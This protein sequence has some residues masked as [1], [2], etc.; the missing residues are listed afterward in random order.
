M[1]TAACPA[2]AKWPRRSGRTST[3]ALMASANTPNRRPVS[4]RCCPKRASAC[5]MHQGGHARKSRTPSESTNHAA[6]TRKASVRFR[7]NACARCA[8]ASKRAHGLDAARRLCGLGPS[9]RQLRFASRPQNGRS[10]AA[11]HPSQRRGA[12]RGSPS[13][14]PASANRAPR[15]S[16]EGGNPSSSGRIEAVGAQWELPSRNP[17]GAP[18]APR[19][20]DGRDTP[21]SVTGRTARQGSRGPA[22]QLLPFC[23][24]RPV[25]LGRSARNL[26]KPVASQGV[27]NPRKPT[28]TTK[29]QWGPVGLPRGAKARSRQRGPVA[30]LGVTPR[31]NLRATLLKGCSLHDPIHAS[32][33]AASSTTPSLYW[34]LYRSKSSMSSFWGTLA[35]HGAAAASAALATVRPPGPLSWGCTG[36]RW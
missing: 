31:K 26:G 3:V 7:R 21:T 22:S 12:K 24:A 14:N 23:R 30:P 4:Y 6:K 1:P 18:A 35:A 36:G 13:R 28:S 29:A 5:D 15:L 19:L 25:D 20:A 32:R 10:R 17:S 8:P 27:T 34:P 2:A 33:P 11:F 16:D 9:P